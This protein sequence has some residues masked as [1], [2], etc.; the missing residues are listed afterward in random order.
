M[1]PEITRLNQRY[2]PALALAELILRSASI[3]SEGGQVVAT[4]FVFDMNEVFESFLT[5]RLTERFKQ[6]G[7][8]VASQRS[9]KLAATISMR[10][11]ITWHGA[12]GV[13]AVVDAK[14]KSLVDSSSMPNAD[15]YQMLAYCIALGLPRGYLV[16][17]KDAA[18]GRH[19][20]RTLRHGYEIDVRALDVELE[21]ESLLAQVDQIADEIATAWR[22]EGQAA[23]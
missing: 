4:S 3:T 16:Y 14:Y 12:E 10:T 13:R 7:G 2:E 20:H 23:A 22:S 19:T 5:T 1:A 15:A 11:D 21:P 8:W 9:A 17:A 6:H 18:E